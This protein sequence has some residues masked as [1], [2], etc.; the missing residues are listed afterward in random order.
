MEQVFN[1]LDSDV[2][3]MQQ[4]KARIL[5]ENGWQDYND[6]LSLFQAYYYY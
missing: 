4:F 6:L 2:R 3:D 5:S 1:A